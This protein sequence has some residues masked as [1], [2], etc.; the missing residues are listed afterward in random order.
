MR[1]MRSRHIGMGMDLNM[2]IYQLVA[3]HKKGVSAKK[4]CEKHQ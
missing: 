3:M 2:A 4:Q 1:V